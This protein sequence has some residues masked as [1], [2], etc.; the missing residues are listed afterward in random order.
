MRIA[1]IYWSGTGNTESMAH[2]IAEGLARAQVDYDV[3]P[4]SGCSSE[5]IDQYDRFMLGCPA[6]GDEELEESEFLPFFESIEQK[7][8]G[9]HIALFGSYD[10][11]DGQWMRSWEKQVVG[12]HAVL[13]EHGLIVQ[14]APTGPTQ[15]SCR[16]F[17]KRFAYD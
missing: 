11:G 16:E 9:K 17:G 14:N 5:V 12:N 10:W 8:T 3:M 1:I 13:F 15:D 7:L 4:V 6:M 2:L